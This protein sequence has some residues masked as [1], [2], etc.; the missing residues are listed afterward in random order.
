MKNNAL[1]I[2]GNTPLRRND[3]GLISLTDIFKASGETTRIETRDSG[4]EKK[5]LR[6][7]I[8]LPII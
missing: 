5:G 7:S 6:L 8:L 1:A 2:I 3:E 4:Q